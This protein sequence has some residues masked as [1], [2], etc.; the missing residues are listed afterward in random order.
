MLYTCYSILII[1]SFAKKKK[2][3]VLQLYSSAGATGL[4]EVKI[5]FATQKQKQKKKRYCS[6]HQPCIT[7]IWIYKDLKWIYSNFYYVKYLYNLESKNNIC[8][9]VS[10]SKIWM[11]KKH[12]LQIKFALHCYICN[13]QW[14]WNI[15]CVVAYLQTPCS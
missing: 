1:I 5:C 2:L 12:S 8:S 13:F 15:K 10:F 4:S 7:M 6:N 11:V 3:P 9:T 14:I